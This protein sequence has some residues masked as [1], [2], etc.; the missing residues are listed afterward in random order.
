M[1]APA[2]QVSK[3]LGQAFILEV[4]FI[5]FYT[6]AVP[7]VADDRSCEIAKGFDLHGYGIADL[8]AT[9][10][11]QKDPAAGYIHG[12]TGVQVVSELQ[13]SAIGRAIAPVS[14]ALVLPSTKRHRAHSFSLSFRC[15]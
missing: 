6:D 14:A 7:G 9:R 3:I 1:Q 11:F 12:R 15:A 5:K 2:R 4:D 10:G 8:R 13:R